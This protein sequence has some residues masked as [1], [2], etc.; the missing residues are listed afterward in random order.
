MTTT[1]N[2]PPHRGRVSCL[3]LKVYGP[4]GTRR[5]GHQQHGHGAPRP[6]RGHAETGHQHHKPPPAPQAARTDTAQAPQ[7]AQAP[8][9]AQ[10]HQRRKRDATTGR[11][12]GG[13]IGTGH[14]HRFEQTATLAPRDATSGHQRTSHHGRTRDT[15][16][17]GKGTP[18]RDTDGHQPP[19]RKPRT[20]QAGALYLCGPA[21]AG[22]V[23][24]LSLESRHKG[25]RNGLQEWMNGHVVP[26]RLPK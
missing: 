13:Q 12:T 18:P 22:I 11:A 7:A 9:R 2:A 14:R 24:S 5:H 1:E 6:A 4:R 15:G 20:R 19:R 10:G 3:L 23:S 25:H 21:G 17:G 16:H 8:R 26:E